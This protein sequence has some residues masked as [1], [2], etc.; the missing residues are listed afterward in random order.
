MRSIHLPG[1]LRAFHIHLPENLSGTSKQLTL[2]LAAL[3]VVFGDI[4]TSPLYAVKE[5]FHGLHAIPV[6]EGNILGVMS[7]VVW[8]LLIMV[9][10]KYLTFIMHAD[11]NGEGGIFALTA[12]FLSGQ[13]KKDL[14]RRVVAALTMLAIFGAALLYGDGVITPAISVLSAIE[15]LNVA[16]EAA[17]PF[18]IP[19]TCLI[20]FLL[21]MVQNQGS[22]KIGLVFGVVMTLWFGTISLLGLRLIWINPNILLAFNPMYAASFF[23]S[24][25]LHGMVVLGSVVLCITGGEALYADMGHFGRGPIRLSW[26]ALVLPALLCNYFGQ[27]A[28]LLAHPELATNPFYGLVPKVLLYPMVVLSTAATVIAS[29][30]MI[31]GIFSLTHQAVQLGFS[32]RLRIVHTSDETKGQ[33]YIPWVNWMMMLACI[34]LVLIFKDSSRLAGAYGIAVTATMA[35]TTIIYAFVTRLGWGWPFWKTA[36]V[37]ILLFTFD[38]VYLGSNMLK[39]VDGGWLT[40]LMACVAA[41][42]MVTWRDGRNILSKRI[43]DGQIPVDILLKDL[44]QDPPHR[45]PGV[46]VFLSVSPQ[47]V[48]QAL[49]HH[50]KHNETLHEK[51]VLLSILASDMPVVPREKRLEISD[52]GQGFHRVV[53]SYGFMEQ[54]NIPEVFALASDMGLEL[55][56]FDASFYLGRETLLPSGPSRMAGWRKRLFAFM[57]RNAWNVSPYFAIPAERVVE[58]GRQV[59]L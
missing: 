12:M 43:Q 59:E 21:F 16:T 15:G 33:I 14:P 47:G 29:Q 31:S 39:I 48:P 50:L 58:L 32:P 45:T 53:A 5:C 6:T 34:A 35:I 40:L 57:T 28:L 18:V 51:I 38:A 54:P 55:D 20:I 4:G 27:G 41:V 17:K 23:M 8:S 49:L 30:A 56:L 13:R 37:F 3:G 11:N 2:T 19:L 52:I 36:A 25:G 26:Y 46:G 1:P 44:A 9:S 22:G 24:H 10:L 7:L 42:I